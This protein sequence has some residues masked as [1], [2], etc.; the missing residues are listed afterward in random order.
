VPS[1]TEVLHK[2]AEQGSQALLPAADEIVQHG[3]LA[4]YLHD[5]LGP[6]A[7]TFCGSMPVA[8]RHPNGF[9]KIRLASLKDFDWTVRLHIWAKGS[10]DY[11]IHSHRWDFASRVIFGSLAEN[12]YKLT[13]GEGDYRQYR[14]SPSLEGRYTLDFQSNCNVELDDQMWYQ[15]GTSYERD[16]R[17]LHMAHTNSSSGA[18]TFFVQG[19]AA[20]FSTTVIRRPGWDEVA[21]NVVAPRCSNRELIALLKETTGLL[22]YG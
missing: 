22:A 2:Y 8:Y 6:R 14:C 19:P 16:A 13:A 7:A 3:H 9:I 5:Q 10:S 1:L 15:Q 20:K 21:R 17:A 18:V 12:T 4:E 11:D